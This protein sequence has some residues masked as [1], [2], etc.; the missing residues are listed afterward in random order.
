[1]YTRCTHRRERSY[2][3]CCLS[4]SMTDATFPTILLGQ[5]DCLK[6]HASYQNSGCRTAVCS[7]A[8]LQLIISP[9]VAGFTEDEEKE[10][11]RP[12]DSDLP[13][14]HPK[15]KHVISFTSPSIA[16][17]THMTQVSDML[18]RREKLLSSSPPTG[19]VANDHL[20]PP[21]LS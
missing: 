19:Q 21:W 4:R 16:D 3:L 8:T 10:S 2:L 7:I 13:S 14:C 12:P 18:N 6:I 11:K 9:P 17:N 5:V 20:S 15:S 1:M